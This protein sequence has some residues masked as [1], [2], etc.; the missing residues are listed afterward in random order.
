MFFTV[1]QYH[2]FDARFNRIFAADL[3]TKGQRSSVF[4]P[5][6]GLPEVE[7]YSGNTRAGI[8]L[9]RVAKRNLHGEFDVGS[10]RGKEAWRSPTC[11]T[12]ATLFGS[13]STLK[14]DTN[15]R[16]DVPPLFS[17]AAY[18]RKV[19]LALSVSSPIK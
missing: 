13:A 16:E 17:P 19:G 7:E 9:A 6:L 5:F 14:L 15:K 1:P 18:N 12:A 3:L 8:L 2:S 4:F 11:P 10:P